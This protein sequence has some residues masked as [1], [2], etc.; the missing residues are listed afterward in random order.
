MSSEDN[1]KQQNQANEEFQKNEMP[2]TTNLKSFS[3]TNSE[4]V[5]PRD[6][7]ERAKGVQKTSKKRK[8]VSFAA[9]DNEKEQIPSSKTS[10]SLKSDVSD[11]TFK[12][13]SKVLELNDKDK[14]IRATPVIPDD[15]TPEELALRREMLEYSL[16]EVGN[17]VA[18]LDLCEDEELSSLSDESASDIEDEYGRQ[19]GGNI[20]PEYRAQMQELQRKVNNSLESDRG[21][22]IGISRT[23]DNKS[24]K[25]NGN[26]ITPV[27]SEK[28]NELAPKRPPT[29]AKK[30]LRFADKV[31]VHHLPNKSTKKPNKKRGK[32][33][34]NLKSTETSLTPAQA[35]KTGPVD[36]LSS[37][38]I[39]R[40]VKE[41]PASENSDLDTETLLHEA[42]TNYY[43]IRNR[44]IQR[45]GGFMP[46]EE[47]EDNPLMEEHNGQ[48]RKVSR[49]K[50]ARLK[51]ANAE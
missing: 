44:A 35:S 26:P 4:A 42:K 33:Y 9:A 45:Q 41:R 30:S 3:T 29:K 39:E 37:T 22:T 34:A 51:P 12:A 43:D 50:A 48:V 40:Q 36:T 21:K 46:T 1:V 13:G 6:K 2:V 23:T 10:Q 31:E 5:E 27:P 47:E 14:P 20:T 19:L 8:K 49:F 28:I 25:S 32:H 16:N 17:V 7:I 15:E 24:D 38:V 18:E 11:F